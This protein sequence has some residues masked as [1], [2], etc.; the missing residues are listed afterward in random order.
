MLLGICNYD[1]FFNDIGPVLRLVCR[2]ESQ[3][4]V[5]LDI[6]DDRLMPRMIILKEDYEIFMEVIESFNLQHLIVKTGDSLPTEYEEETVAIYTTFPRDIYD[7]RRAVEELRTFNSDIKWEKMCIQQLGWKGFIE[8]DDELLDEYGFTPL[9]AITV[10]KIVFNINF[11]ICYW[12]IETDGSATKGRQFAD[13]RFAP[14]ILIITY[15]TFS[16]HAGHYTYYGWKPDWKREE[17]WDEHKTQLG[18]RALNMPLF[19]EYS[20]TFPLLVKKFSNEKDMHLQFMTDFAR[21]QYDGLMTFNGRGGNRIVRKKRKWFNGFDM[22]MFYERCIHLGLHEEIQNLSSI[23]ATKKWGRISQESLKRRIRTD[24][25]KIETGREYHIKCIPQHD[26]LYDDLVLFYSKNEHEMKRHNLD[27]YLSHFLGIHKVEHKGLSVAQLHA[28]NWKKGM[29]YNIVDVE[30]MVALDILF[31]YTTDV[32]LRA[33]AYGGKIEDAVYASKLHDH[34][35]LWFVRNRY[36]LPTR[37]YGRKNMRLGQWGGLLKTK[38]GGFNLEPIPGVYGYHTPQIIFVVDFSKLYPSCSRSANVDTRTKINLKNISFDKKGIWLVDADG[39]KYPYH[40]CAR[41]PAGFFRKDIEAIDTIIYNEMIELR[42][43]YSKKSG[44]YQDLAAHAKTEEE[45]RN[46]SSMRNVYWATQFSYKGLINGKYG[47]DGMEGTR[48]FDYVVYNSPPSMGQE[49]IKFVIDWLADRGY[50]SILAST[51]SAFSIAKS[52]DPLKAW[53]E[54]QELTTMLNKDLEK[55]AYKEFNIKDNYINI[56]CEKVADMAVI[57]DKRKYMLNT[58]VMEEGGK[59]IVLEKPKAY[60]KGM[61]YV[62]RDSAMIT[63]DVQEKL[64]NMVRAKAPK[65]EI[66]EYIRKTDKEFLGNTWEYICGRGGIS[67]GV[68]E[69]SGQKYDGCKLANKIFKKSYDSGANPLI[70]EFTKHP[71]NF[72]GVFLGYDPLAIAFDENDQWQLKKWGFDINYEN[73]KKVALKTKVEP[74]LGLLFNMTYDEA[75]DFDDMLDH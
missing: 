19:K 41:T 58:V 66:L 22:P 8:V 59:V 33:L 56:G 45:R 9:D 15:V 29:R 7:L 73:R 60:F 3:Q 67:M 18:K 6:Q 43:V 14:K 36:V 4:R 13:C 16:K 49:L 31:R 71:I 10:S 5:I 42:K 21:G 40:E 32:G 25:N 57:F 46:Y 74:L 68:E 52:T 62:R 23:S 28:K 47:A 61:E 63:H 55:Y 2:N 54:V 20:H 70:A 75:I 35:K 1:H 17:F 72:A 34:I 50:V 51:D 11:N 38:I 39:T 65:E 12:D 27:T 48:G 24:I 44:E 69:G 64:M 26:L 37:V 53:D 30:G